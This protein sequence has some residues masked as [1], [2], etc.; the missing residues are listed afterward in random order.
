MNLII[1]FRNKSKERKLIIAIVKIWFQ[2]KFKI[3]TSKTDVIFKI[4]M[5]MSMIKDINNKKII[6]IKITIK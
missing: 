1:I 6:I 3:I 5:R 4:K 2:Q